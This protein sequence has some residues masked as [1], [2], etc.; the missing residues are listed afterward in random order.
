MSLSVVLPVKFQTVFPSSCRLN[1]PFTDSLSE[2]YQCQIKTNNPAFIASIPSQR[3]GPVTVA[4]KSC[5]A[6]GI[7]LSALVREDE[8]GVEASKEEKKHKCSASRRRGRRASSSFN[9]ILE[10]FF[11]QFNSER[12]MTCIPFRHRCPNTQFMI[13]R[14]D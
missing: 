6:E 4:T 3:T 7:G 10:F 14:H 13:S 11:L 12:D 2:N 8:K 1:C 5:T 9:S